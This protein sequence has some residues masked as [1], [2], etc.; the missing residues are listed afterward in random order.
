MIK[1]GNLRKNK[2]TRKGT[3]FSI[4][5]FFLFSMIV[6]LFSVQNVQATS[7]IDEGFEDGTRG[8]FSTLEP[9]NHVVSTVDPYQGTYHLNTTAPGWSAG[10]RIYK[11][12]T[13]VTEIYARAFA[14]MNTTIVTG[15]GVYPLAVT[16]DSYQYLLS[17]IGFMNV[18]GTN[19][20]AIQ[21]RNGSTLQEATND[22]A[23]AD[24]YTDYNNIQVH[25]VIDGSAGYVE[26]YVDDVKV[27][28]VTGLNN[29]AYGNIDYVWSG[30]ASLTHN[31]DNNK[32]TTIFIDTIQA[33]DEYIG[34]V[35]S[36]P[37][38]LGAISMNSTAAEATANLTC[39]ATDTNGVDFVW[40][41][42]NATGT[43]TNQTAI[44]ANEA[45]P[46][47]AKF[48]LTNPTP[49]KLMVQCF[50][51]D[52]SGNTVA[53]DLTY[54]NIVTYT[55]PDHYL[56]VEGNQVINSSDV[57]IKLEGVNVNT[58]IDMP[59][60]FWMNED[61]EY[62]YGWNTANVDRT[63]RAIADW[64]STAIR[65]T[66]TVQ[67][68]VD[69]EDHFR[70][71]I[72]YIL[73]WCGN[74][75]IAVSFC[76]YRSNDTESLPTVLPWATGNEYLTSEQDFID[77]W[78]N[79]TTELKD[80]P[81]FIVELW[82]EPQGNGA[83]YMS[84]VQR[85]V[86][87]IRSIPAYNPIV[88]QLGYGVGYDYGAGAGVRGDMTWVADYP[89]T[90]MGSNLIMSTHVYGTNFYNSSAG[91]VRVTNYT[92][93]KQAFTECDVY[94]VAENYPLWFGEHGFNAW[95]N[96]TL[97]TEYFTNILTLLNETDVTDG[98]AGFAAWAWRAGPDQFPLWAWSGGT[99]D[100][101]NAGDIII[102]F[103]A[104]NPVVE[105][106]YVTVASFVTPENITYPEPDVDFEVSTAGSNDTGI[107][108]QV[109]LFKAGVQVGV[110]QTSLTGS[111]TGLVNGTYTAF[112]TAVGDNGATDTAQV[113]FTVAI[114]P[115]STPPT[116][117]VLGHTGSTGG[118]SGNFYM[119][120]DD[121]TALGT[122]VFSYKIGSGSYANSSATAFS[123][124]PGWA[125]VSQT[126]PAQNVT[127][128]FKY[129][130]CDSSGSW[131]VTSE[132]SFAV[133]YVSSGEP[134]PTPTPTPTPT[135]SPTATPAPTPTSPVR[136]G[137]TTNLYFRSDTYTT[138]NVSAYGLDK[139]YT[140]TAVTSN[141]QF[142]VDIVQYAF[143][144]YL[145]SSSVQKTELT[146]GYS[147]II[148]LTS[149]STGNI[150]GY[151][152]GYWTMPETNVILGY[153]A[154][155]FDIYSYTPSSL[156]TLEK[157]FITPV[158]ITKEILASSLTLQLYVNTTFTT[159]SI[160]GGT[161]DVTSS[162]IF[163]DVTHKSG[164]YELTMT[165]PRQSDIQLWRINSGD[166]IGFE[167]GAY[168]DLIGEA[169]YVLLLILFAGVLY[170]RYGSFG[171]VAFFFVLFG[172]FGG[173]VWFLLP[174]WAAGVASALII[175]GTSFIVW[176]VIR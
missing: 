105:D 166:Y 124:T 82:N 25:T 77:L 101:N 146:S 32:I 50:A 7:I 103:M 158:L 157:S 164:I 26:M 41:A 33:S 132:L 83:T 65:L 21:Y 139:D 99:F 4:V 113:I 138:L 118:T 163:G 162:F 86:T 54:F 2:V 59:S 3:A 165:T 147:A 6:P 80:Y 61:G 140:N 12:I 57:A 47:T 100:P 142:D 44:D 153:Q 125:N 91:S 29:S 53:S 19:R 98:L 144:V 102:S 35:D 129:Y 49:S 134:E 76:A 117:T 97:E 148:T 110:N 1:L 94:S 161:S 18:S 150:T 107:A 62:V 108:V 28:E 130:F 92:L 24:A 114:P 78:V 135:P 141:V 79:I 31:G 151:V 39:T 90:D 45:S 5:L 131:N 174:S 159:P 40:F 16:G 96:A 64:H 87:A 56:H 143:R 156:W 55:P 123:S 109:G 38:T 160:Y 121:D 106:S 95:Q 69:D 155:Q 22:T 84:V 20:Y 17:S 58:M 169:F 23:T 48:T 71:N 52:T 9:A 176:R 170:F 171:T 152:Y 175:L 127:L 11:S 168:V 13:G 137:E 74:H 36:T 15:V 111:F 46:F 115:V 104:E 136:A 10:T 154:L 120:A 89:I 51:N 119:L 116:Y 172:G 81:A 43:M 70:D 149:N 88:I 63:L 34:G 8:V 133:T 27:L 30:A 42:H 66:F 37:P 128:Y 60:G 72:K 122:F 14:R 145:V 93:L 126:L 67:F 85:T 112:V 167:I 68:W 73:N 75:S 173:L